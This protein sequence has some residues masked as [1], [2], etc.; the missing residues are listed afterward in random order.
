MLLFFEIKGASP[1]NF[2]SLAIWSPVLSNLII[3]FATRAHG[4]QNLGLK[5]YLGFMMSAKFVGISFLDQKILSEPFGISSI[6]WD[7]DLCLLWS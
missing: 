2:V 3:V 6:D 5:D 1:S 4:T 7:L